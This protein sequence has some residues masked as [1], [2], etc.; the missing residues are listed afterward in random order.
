[1]KKIISAALCAALSLTLLSGCSSPETSITVAKVKTGAYLEDLTYDGKI[2]ASSSI[3]IIPSVSGKVTSVNVDIGTPV[4]TGQVLFTIDDTT[5]KLQLKQS[6]ASFNSANANY[7]K[8]VGASNPQAESQ[9]KQ[10]LERAE[11]EL[12]DATSS[13]NNTK[14]QYESNSLVAPAQASYDNAKSNYERIAFLVESG[15]ESQYT[16]DT[17]KNSLDTA[18][19]QLENTKSQSKS[20]MDSADSRLNN[21]KAALDAAK[22]NFTLTISNMNP[23]NAKV[24]KSQIESAQAALDIAKKN[25]SDTILKAPMDGHI[26][27][28]LI[29][30][31]DMV[32]SQA[33][34][35]IINPSKME[36]MIEVSDAYIDDIFNGIGKLKAEVL[37][38]A[39]G[40]T[41]TGTVSAASPGADPKTGL[42]SVKISFSKEAN[43]LKDGMLASAR[44]VA[45][46]SVPEIL[47]P[48]KSIVTEAS[49]TYVYI[50]AGGKLSKTEVT[51]GETKNSY[52]AV[53]GLEETD[54]VV[55]DGADKVTEDGKFRILS[56]GN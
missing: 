10:A 7:S 33:A 8:V 44:L 17:A 37:V 16:L 42:Y 56:I 34:M 20:S 52:I 12:R 5:A 26:A 38:S 41:V 53:T 50:V 2:S 48:Q 15:E 40:E 32:S 14:S 46:G 36:M 49:K 18:L 3:A 28:K 11:N 47:V 54:S 25:V 1:M 21:A 22:Q 27:S 6:Q 9:A 29:K 51:T 24:A 31:G 30:T 39:T 55:V 4:K 45:E 13:Y 43:R 35:T 19:A 23:E